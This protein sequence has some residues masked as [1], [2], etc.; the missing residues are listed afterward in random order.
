MLFGYPYVDDNMTAIYISSMVVILSLQ[1]DFYPPLLFPHFLF[2][3]FQE[4]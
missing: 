1:M 4:I 2:S 3:I